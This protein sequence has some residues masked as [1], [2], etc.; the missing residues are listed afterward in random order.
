MDVDSKLFSEK[1]AVKISNKKSDWL[2][3]IVKDAAPGSIFGS[4][5][6]NVHSNDLLYV[7]MEMSDG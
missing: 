6:Y 3:V 4:F 1:K 7:Y 5:A 2:Y